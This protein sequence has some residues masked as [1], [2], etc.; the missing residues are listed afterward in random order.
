[1][2]SKVESLFNTELLHLIVLYLL[3]WNRSGM[4]VLDEFIKWCNARCL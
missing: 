2:S 1:M 4:V 3:R